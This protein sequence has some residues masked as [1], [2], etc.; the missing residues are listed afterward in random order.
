MVDY[1]HFIGMFDYLHFM[2]FVIIVYIAVLLHLSWNLDT[3]ITFVHVNI[4]YLA[5]GRKHTGYKSHMAGLVT[6]WIYDAFAGIP[7]FICI[8]FFFTRLYELTNLV[9]TL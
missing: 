5:V 6:E 9:L 4:S 1:L 3:S 8:T 7:S 2:D